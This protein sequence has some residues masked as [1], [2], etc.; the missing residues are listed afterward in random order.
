MVKVFVI[1]VCR[2]AG[3]LLEPTM[4][5]VLNQTYENI[6]YIVVDG[7]STDG[8]IEIIRKYKDRL[9]SWI[10]EPDKGIYDAMNKGVEIAKSLLDDGEDAWVNFM[11]AGDSF[12]QSDTI[13]RLFGAEGTLELA[14]NKDKIYVVGGNTCDYFTDGTFRI[15][16]AESADV[17]TYRLA[18]SHQSCFVRIGTTPNNTT[19]NGNWTFDTNYRFA[20]DY[21]LLHGIYKKYGKEAFLIV[22]QTIARYL[23]NESSSLDNWRKTGIEYLRIQFAVF[24]VNWWKNVYRFFRKTIRKW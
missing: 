15:H 2:N 20:A 23:Q 5:S 14:K 24:S 10:S 22:N 17:L 4:L 3:D 18:F 11:N 21:N 19:F 8:T 12:E 16:Y 1:T 13:S 9:A 7:A 6:S